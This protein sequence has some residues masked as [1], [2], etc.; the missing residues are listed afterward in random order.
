MKPEERGEVAARVLALAREFHTMPDQIKV[1]REKADEAQKNLDRARARSRV[2]APII[3][4]EDPERRRKLTAEDRDAYVVLDTE[5]EFD[6]W[7]VANAAHEYQKDRVRARDKELSA[8]Q[9]L[10]ADARQE[11]RIL[12]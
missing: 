9:T 3:D 10:Q 5:D 8:L 12:G 6:A 2:K 7:L 4:P 1:T 11:M